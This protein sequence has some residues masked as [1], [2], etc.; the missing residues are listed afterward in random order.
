MAGKQNWSVS[1][2]TF[3]IETLKE[4]KIIERLDG[5]KCRNTEL[6]KQVHEKLEEAGIHRTIEQIKKRWKSLKAKYYQAKNK[7]GRSGSDPTT[8]SFYVLMDELMRERPLANTT[9]SGVDQGYEEESEDYSPEANPEQSIL[10]DDESSFDEAADSSTQQTTVQETFNRRGHQGRDHEGT[11]VM[12][13]WAT[14]QQSFYQKMQESQ[15]KWIE[16]QQ[17]RWQQREERLFVKAGL[18]NFLRT[19]ATTRITTSMT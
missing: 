1:D 18:L 14:E 5:R 4:L 3:L 2:T 12:Q 16:E 19:Q 11:L 10:S 8:F 17:E 9:G 6:F 7:N 13:T 15:N